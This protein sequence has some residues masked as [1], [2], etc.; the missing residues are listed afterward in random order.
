MCV[1]PTFTIATDAENLD[2]DECDKEYSH[3]D[4]D[5]QVRAPISNRETG[6]R[7]LERQHGEPADRV[8]PTDGKSPTRWSAML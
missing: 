7:K 5:V 2:D 8:V 4:S 3:P 6:S 1:L